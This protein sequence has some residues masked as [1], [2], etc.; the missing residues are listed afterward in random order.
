MMTITRRQMTL[1]ASL[2]PI[3]ALA[4]AASASTYAVTYVTDTNSPSR[5]AVIANDGTLFGETSDGIFSR[6]AR[7]VGG[8]IVQVPGID[9]A[10][11]NVSSNGQR[12]AGVRVRPD[13]S[14][15]AV[16]WSA[17]DGYED[18]TEGL[19]GEG[20][21]INNAG[22]LVG[23]S[24]G[25]AVIFD[26]SGSPQ[27]LRLPGGI[28]GFGAQARGI[29]DN[30]MVVGTALSAS[31]SRRAFAYT[32]AT[33]V[34][35]LQRPGGSVDASESRAN[36][37]N[38]SGWVVGAADLA[39]TGTTLSMLWRDGSF[40]DLGLAP[41]ATSSE[42]VAIN[43]LGAIVGNDTA[44][45]PGSQGSQAWLWVDGIR[46]DLNDLVPGQLDA[47]W[48][49]DQALSINDS[50]QI[51]VRVFNGGTFDSR[52]AVLNIIPTPAAS[53]TLALAGL[54]AMRRRR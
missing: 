16:R 40:I 31:G 37:V 15:G 23:S 21:A 53:A 11:T 4:G 14:L 17:V 18:L 45:G 32:A 26:P 33:G 7:W 13:F 22:S 44:I 9:G 28:S 39:G 41:G 2:L 52:Y 42:A 5:P 54:L 3:A 10:F 43:A 12:L 50:G 34:V 24:G 19:T 6:P 47:G 49:I 25:D 8:S 46:R 27:T 48:A 51:L 1:A 35:E 20:L 30:G 36:A 38:A 29:N